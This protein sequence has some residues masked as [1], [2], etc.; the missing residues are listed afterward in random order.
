MISL[1][2][3]EKPDMELCKMNCD[4]GI[5]KH[6][7]KYEM[8]NHLN[9]HQMTLMIGRPASGKTSLLYSFF[10]T[11]GKNKILNGV[12]STIYLFQP[13]N[14]RASMKDNIFEDE[15]PEDQ[16]YDE[17]DEDNL[18]VVYERV[19]KDAKE[20]YTS[21]IIFDDQGAYLK[22]RSTL[23]MFKEMFFNRR[24]LKLSCYF[25]CQTFYSFPKDLRRIWSN[26]FI[27]KVSK[28][29]MN[30][31]FDELIEQKKEVIDEIMPLVFDKPYEYLM[32]N[33][34]SQKMYKKFDQIVIEKDIKG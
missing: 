15:L 34:D 32:I 14:S 25:A 10:K 12:Y 23:K 21:C 17:L 30:N 8:L 6:L 1:K 3:N 24:H 27:F 4:K 5:A 26:L 16:K 9:K 29:E 20:G 19:K 13:M 18:R 33:I 7:H 2:I 28:D 11:T 22:D 31:I